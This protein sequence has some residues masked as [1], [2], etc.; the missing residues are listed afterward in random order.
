MESPDLLLLAFERISLQ[1]LC[2]VAN[3]SDLGTRYEYIY[4]GKMD[5]LIFKT[6]YYI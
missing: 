4:I 1:C 3:V 6:A 5:T 2:T